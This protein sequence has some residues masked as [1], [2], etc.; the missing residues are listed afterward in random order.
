MNLI[1]SYCGKTFESYWTKKYCSLECCRE[2]DKKRKR[3]TYVGKREKTCR[4]CGKELPKYKS[5]F[6]CNECKNKYNRIKTGVVQSYEKK[7]RI[8]VVC[9]KIFYSH[10]QDK[11]ACSIECTN[12]NRGKQRYNGIIVDK[13]IDLKKLSQRDNGQCMLCGLFVDWEDY[14]KKDGVVVCGGMYPSIDHIIPISL[15]GL[16]SWDN[17]QLAHRICNSRKGNRFIG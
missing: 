2:A 5:R 14:E 12:I 10:R 7:K 6:C 15:G 13:D 17:V 16:H 8:C 1:C 3:E 11:K 4:F 9:G